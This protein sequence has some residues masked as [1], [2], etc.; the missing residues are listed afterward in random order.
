MSIF[1][2]TPEAFIKQKAQQF[3]YFINQVLSGSVPFP[4]VQLFT[5][6][7][8]EEW[9]RLDVEESDD[10]S[11][12]E[13]VFWHAFY[14]I[15]SSDEQMLLSDKLIQQELNGCCEFLELKTNKVPQGCVG[16]RP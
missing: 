13:R 11:A 5:W 3:A 10:I 1:I 6:D 15:Q 16:L 4:E 12:L 2:V 9:N 7:I 14:V 8:L